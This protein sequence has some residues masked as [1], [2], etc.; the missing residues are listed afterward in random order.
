MVMSLAV[1]GILFVLWL[2]FRRLDYILWIAATLLFG[3]VFSLGLIGLIK[4]SL[5]VIVI[6]MGSVIVGIAANYPLHFLHSLSDTADNRSSLKEMSLPLLVGNITTVS[7]FLCLIFLKAEAMHDLALFGA[8]MLLGAI[9]FSLVFLPVLAVRQ[10]GRRQ[11]HRTVK[12]LLYLT[13]G[14]SAKFCL[15]WSLL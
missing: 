13:A 15:P 2:S 6:G 7:A 12:N 1:I 3:A 4:D 9:I 11:T 14:V 5:S 10:N 8:F